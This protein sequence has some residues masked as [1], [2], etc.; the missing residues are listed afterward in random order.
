MHCIVC[1]IVLISY[2][3]SK[4]EHDLFKHTCPSFCTFMTQKGSF[5]F[6]VCTKPNRNTKRSREDWCVS[7]CKH[8]DNSNFWKILSFSYHGHGF[9]TWR[10]HQHIIFWFCIHFIH[11]KKQ[12]QFI[13]KFTLILSLA[14]K[15]IREIKMMSMKEMI[16]M[17]VQYSLK[18]FCCCS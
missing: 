1:K 5:K 2:F 13:L 16:I 15:L 6:C 8:L 4:N 17:I 18:S 9:S 14:I 10:L 3:V 12:T 11:I 7:I